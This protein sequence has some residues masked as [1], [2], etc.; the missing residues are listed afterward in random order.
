MLHLKRIVVHAGRKSHLHKRLFR[1][2]RTEFYKF[3]FGT[4]AAVNN[5]ELS[6]PADSNAIGSLLTRAVAGDRLAVEQLVD[7]FAVV[8]AREMRM[9][10]RF[11]S[12][13]S[14]LD[15]EDIAQSVWRCFFTALVKGELVFRE[16]GEVAAFLATLARNRIQTQV[17]K[18]TASKRDVRRTQHAAE[19]VLVA[20]DEDSPLQSMVVTEMLQAILQNM[21]PEERNIARLRADGVSW[22]EIAN[23][24]NTTAEA[25]RKRHARTTERIVR[26]H[27]G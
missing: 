9:L 24:L 2:I 15:S 8:I 20:T 26:E 4:I 25:V 18:H 6:A 14:R 11:Q 23:H 19:N 1:P 17:R 27:E 3:V 12:L 13:Q 10:R 22:A 5:D 21:T 16:A 7:D